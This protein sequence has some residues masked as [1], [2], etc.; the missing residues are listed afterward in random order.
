M[1][2]DTAKL[3]P[4]T[5]D[6]NSGCNLPDATILEQVKHN[7][8]LGHQQ[9]KPYEPNPA[10][11]LLVCG[12]PSLKFTE[13]D[14]VEATWR[15]GKVVTVNAAYDWCLDR[16]IRP[17]ATIMLDGRE[18]N[19]RFVERNVPECRYLLASQCHPT[20]FEMC[21]DR[22]VHIWHACSGGDEE[23]EIVKQFYFDFTYPVTIGTTVAIR[24]IS[25]LRMLGFEFIEIFGL[26]SCW[27]GDDHHAYEQRENDHD[28][29]L[30]VWLRPQAADGS[31]RDDLT[32]SFNCS[33]WHVKQAEDFQKLTEDRGDKFQLNVHGPGL[34]ATMIRTGAQLETTM[35]K[36][37]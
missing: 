9:V 19:K 37:T 15:G 8:R 23:H 4:V 31:Y 27:L 28:K 34:I 35:A 33:P 7:I 24:A 14:L 11:A 17:T 26:D 5:F 18:F 36:E 22:D 20:T 32:T 10:T 12:G 2:F 13:K 1:T 16:N 6:P 30:V 21:K 29:K 25:L 3:H